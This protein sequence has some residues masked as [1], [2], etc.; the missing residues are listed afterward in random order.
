M[1]ITLFLFWSTIFC[2]PLKIRTPEFGS[3]WGS[4]SY[5]KKIKL[6]CVEI[7]TPNDFMDAM[8]T[9]FNIHPVEIIGST[10]H[11]SVVQHLSCINWIKNIHQM[12]VAFM[13]TIR[14]VS[15]YMQRVPR[16]PKSSQ[17]VLTC[18]APTI[19]WDN[20]PGSP[21]RSHCLPQS[22]YSTHAS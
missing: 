3:K 19:W 22:M 14:V 7:K 10:L 2:R 5:E 12:Y 21:Q 15:A 11:R 8:E 18:L 9:R 13:T 20:T 17:H 16:R 4:L 6:P 1:V